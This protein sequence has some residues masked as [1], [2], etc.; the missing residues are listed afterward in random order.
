MKYSVSSPP[1]IPPYVWSHRER[2]G[3]LQN[4]PQLLFPVPLPSTMGIPGLEN[5]DTTPS[6]SVSNCSH[7]SSPSFPSKNN[8]NNKLGFLH[9]F[10]FRILSPAA[11]FFPH[12]CRKQLIWSKENGNV[13]SEKDSA[14]DITT[15]LSLFHTLPNSRLLGLYTQHSAVMEPGYVYEQLCRCVWSTS[16]SSLSH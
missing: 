5:Q 4:C 13:K 7:C 6:H 11:F 1:H 8:N 2:K 12:T 9:E 10:K 15:S 3:K 14:W 16:L